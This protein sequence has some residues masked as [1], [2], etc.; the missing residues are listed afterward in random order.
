LSPESNKIFIWNQSNHLPMLSPESNKIFIWNQSN[1][2]HVV[3]WIKQNIY[4]KSVQSPA[5]V[6]T[7]IK[8][9]IYMKTMLE[10]DESWVISCSYAYKHIKFNWLRQHYK[11]VLKCSQYLQKMTLFWFKLT[12]RR[13]HLHH[14]S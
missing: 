6:V 3:T 4:M 11:S 14:E 12:C 13:I 10:F 1:H 5:H 2:L 7:W 9:N 8:Q